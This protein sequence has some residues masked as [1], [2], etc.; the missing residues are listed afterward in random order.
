[1]RVAGH[2]RVAVR[3]GLRV[4]D[5]GEHPLLEHRRHR[6][7]EPLGLLVDLVPRDPEHV[8]EEALDQAVAAD[9][10]LGVLG[11]RVGER[12]RLVARARD[13]A[14]ALEAADHLV[15]RRGRELHRARD[16]GAGHRQTRLLQPEERLEVLLL[17]DGGVIGHA[18]HR[19]RLRDHAGD[20]GHA[21]VRHRCLARHRARAGRRAGRARRH[22][23]ASPRARPTSSPRSPPSSPAT[24]HVL[25]CDVA[26]AGVHAG[27]RSTRF[28]ERAGGLELLVANAGITHY[29]PFRDQPLDKALQMS[30]VNWH[31]TLHTVHFGLPHLLERRT[32]GTSSS[33]PAAPACA[34]SRRPR[35]TARRRPPSACSPRPCATSSPAPASR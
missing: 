23:R 4:A 22:A 21:G 17:G 32:A 8:G 1:M 6:V 12:D 18:D 13:V 34:R 7:L 28:V 35:S 5:R 14:V 2:D 16:V 10:A 24:H 9:D 26:D 31:G 19:N 25:E 30:Q 20:A 15:H 29:G 33:S 3:A 27:R 11:A